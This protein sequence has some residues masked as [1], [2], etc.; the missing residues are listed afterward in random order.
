[1]TRGYPVATASRGVAAPDLE[2]AVIGAG[3]HGLSAAT[4]L[5]RAGIRAHVF[6]APMAFWRT[7]PEG[8]RLRSNMT[9][10]NMIE[11]VGPL[12]LA[13]YAEATGVQLEQPVP[14][15]D[16]IAYGSWVQR[17]EAPDV[18]ERTVTALQR[19]PGGFSLELDDGERV[20]ARRVV[21]ACGIAS[22]ER[23]P[24]GFDHL[25][26]DRLSHTAHHHDLHVFCGRRVAVVGAG[27]SAFECAALMRECGATQVEVL[28][29][30]PAVVWL[31]GHGVK[32]ILGRLGPIVYAPTDV[33]PLWYSRLVA[34]PDFFRRLPRGTQVRIANRSI[35]PACSHF[36]RVRLGEVRISAGV[37][38]IGAEVDR[39][40]LRV[41]LSDGSE[42]EVDHLMFGTG[43]RVDVTR[44][45]FLGEGILGDMR[46]VDGYPVLS[47]GLESS[48]PGLHI[49]GAPA[50]WSFGPIMR[51]VSGSWYAGR[52]VAREIA[53]RPSGRRVGGVW[54]WRG[55]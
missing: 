31:R 55:A 36:V 30:A 46:R 10:T 2:V 39:D 4:H 1:M 13:G 45:A 43:Y 28:A 51:F 15:S 42:R 7:M 26:P 40:A 22:F 11:P 37:R 47:R 25:P 50:A 23:I 16:F 32:K 38:I 20:S 14:L 29:R 17:M 34:K 18:D 48:V 9:A 3:P 49:V 19:A 21:L 52:A 41:S 53:S 33:G 44:Y 35:R 24:A 5:R 54:P 12:S 6:G 8:M 27:Q